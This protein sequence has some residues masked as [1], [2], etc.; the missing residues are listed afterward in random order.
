[1]MQ[2]VAVGRE[3]GGEDVAVGFVIVDD[4]NARWIMH[5]I[6]PPICDSRRVFSD[7]SE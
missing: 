1:L 7:L 5:D 4:Q 2:L 6:S 3:S